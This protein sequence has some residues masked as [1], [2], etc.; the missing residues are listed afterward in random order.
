[1]AIADDVEW[2]GRIPILADLDREQLRILAFAAE[3]VQLHQGQ[4]LF[5]EGA[6][7]DSAFILT[8]GT[9][10]LSRRD[11]DGA[12]T[13]AKPG[14]A[15]GEMA[16]LATTTRPTTAT[17][18]DTCRLLRLNRSHLRRVLEEYPEIAVKMHA[19]L[20]TKLASMT[21]R[22]VAL[23]ERLPMENDPE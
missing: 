12:A 13:I 3:T 4:S 1:M 16:L 11:Q 22:I 2:L 14:T 10:E 23:G 20:K 9:M 8:R 15:F 18:T 6:N 5:Q 7:A 19:R 17:A 21:G